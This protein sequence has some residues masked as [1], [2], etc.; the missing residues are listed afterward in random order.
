MVT[1]L[2]EVDAVQGC[3]RPSPY[4]HDLQRHAYWSANAITSRYLKSPGPLV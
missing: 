3:A 1:R 4:P 2:K